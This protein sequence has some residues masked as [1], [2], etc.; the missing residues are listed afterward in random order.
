MIGHDSVRDLLEK[1]LP[2]V[3]LLC[4]PRS[5]GKWTLA[6][7]LA[8]VHRVFSVDRFIFADK[9]T[10]TEARKAVTF[11][12][13]APFG[14]FKYVLLSTDEATSSA[15][16]VLLKILEEPPP[17]TR[18]VLVSSNPPPPDTIRSRCEIYRLGPLT[19]KQVRDVLIGQ[20]MAARNA[21]AAARAANGRID[22]A[23]R[24]STSAAH[25]A[26]VT[27]I[28]QAVA[29][30][31]PVAFE[32]AMGGWEEP[33]KDLL[34]RWFVEAL[35]KEWS[36]YDEPD[37]FGLHRSPTMLRRM[38]LSLSASPA[39]QSRLGVQVALQPYLGA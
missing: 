27:G 39:A 37:T 9:L 1:R 3:T 38:L 21:E 26:V 14:P 19:D 24:V 29:T 15:L 11:A 10:V 32:H 17:G 25:R 18:F 7:H 22:A 35:T 4:G 6:V 28:M 5:V 36:L 31:D 13:T 30:K 8:D 33:C 20:G 16:N 12:S 23:L 2:P 34:F